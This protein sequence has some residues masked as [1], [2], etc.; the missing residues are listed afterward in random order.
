MKLLER[1][2]YLNELEA[3]LNSLSSDEGGYIVSISGEAGIG[4]TSLINAFK[5]LVKTRVNFFAGIC[6]DLY[7]PRPL[8]PMYDIAEQINS[9]I[10]NQ[11]DSGI[12][13]PSIFSNLIKEIRLHTPCII[14]IEDVHWA[15]DST[16]DL[17]KFL[18]RRIN[19]L[20][21]LFIITY[22]DDEIKSNHQL[23]LL[24]NNL[25]SGYLKRINLRP[26]SEKAVKSLA[27][28]FG[29][30][31]LNLYDKTGGNPLLVTE[32]LTNAETETPPTI[33]ELMSYKMNLLSAGSRSVIEMISVIPGKVENW[34]AKIL[35]KDYNLIDDP[36]KFGI[37]KIDNDAIIF[38][39]ELIRIAIEDSL[40]ETKRIEF[41]SLVLKILLEQKNKDH[42]LAR[43]IHH[44]TNAKDID[45]IIAYASRAASQASN[46]GAHKLAARHYLTALNCSDNISTEEKLNLLRGRAY[47]CNL[48]GQVEEGIKACELILEILE[49][50]PD[51]H[52]EGE[53][54]R[55]LSKFM[56]AAGEDN[57][58]EKYL[59]KSVMILEKLT[60]TNQLAMAYS[61]LSSIY[62]HRNNSDIALKFGEKAI[63]LAGITNDLETKIHTL[64]NIG[65]C[66]MRD[67][68]DSGEW[69]LKESLKLSLENNFYEHAARAY[70][71]LGAKYLWR[72]NLREAVKYLATGLEYCNEKDLDNIGGSTAGDYAKAKL[73]SGD[74]DDA[75]ELSNYIF[76]SGNVPAA[77]K[78]YPLCVIGQIRARRMDPGALK[79]LDESDYWALK[80]GEID[81]IVTVKAAKAEYYW[82]QN[83]L[84]S[85]IDELEKIYQSLVS[86]RNHWAIGEIAYWLWKS[87]KLTE[88]PKKMANPYML[89]IKGKWKAAA[90]I[91]K[92]LGCPYEY[93]VALS[94]GNEESMK[95]ALE[96]FDDL[97]A[98]AASQLIKQKMREKGIR[99]IP[100]GPRKSTS[101]N[102]GGLTIRQIEVLKL[103][104]KGL[105]NNEIGM[106]LY[107]SPKTVDH[108]ISTI[109]SKLNIHSRTEAAS[110]L[111]SN[112]IS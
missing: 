24:L 65:V 44:A 78:I 63:G 99:S 62:S 30:E 55:I 21:I 25:P 50:S 37:L 81:R 96:V 111:Q 40:F 27:L 71:N 11:L 103:V 66:R 4:K 98:T 89:Q 60:P 106:K 14:V 87:G 22:R 19:N 58:V 51:P 29:R 83:N 6:D 107:I 100:R 23:K 94:E 84:D 68:I 93:A 9:D 43:I 110:F 75:T 85:I 7:T 2:C 47:E 52:R 5:N 61:N 57:L 26:L 73:Y 88:I 34:L 86:S 91:W 39:H 67:S 10:I 101:E 76:K 102:P 108:H 41:N 18:G 70:C 31:D 46:L 20:N 45:T 48:T 105:S 79:L 3:L 112:G 69:Y 49:E 56:W 8:A 59:N 95:K 72:R 17:I 53:I 77:N 12:Q 28:S 109:L 13:R 92:E 15:D 38:K 42:Y 1:D 32:V 33:K 104:G 64:N 80:V 35:I 90:E 74:W 36:L 54:Y 16:F 97:G 82:L